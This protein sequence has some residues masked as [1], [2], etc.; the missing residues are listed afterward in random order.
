M[1]RTILKSLFLCI[2]ISFL[3]FGCVKKEFSNDTWRVEIVSYEFLKA[4]GNYDDPF[5]KSECKNEP[6]AIQLKLDYIGQSGKTRIPDIYIRE[7]LEKTARP[8]DA[9]GID[10]KCDKEKIAMLIK[11]D[12]YKEVEVKQGQMI[13]GEEGCILVF[14]ANKELSRFGLVIDDLPP[15]LIEP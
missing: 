6:L 5:L 3:F 1:S 2:V 11:K 10:S 9:H 15:I 13:F 7:G 4:D 8:Y 14:N 12:Y